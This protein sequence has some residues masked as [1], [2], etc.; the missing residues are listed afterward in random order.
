MVPLTAMVESLE[1]KGWSSALGKSL[2]QLQGAVGSIGSE[3]VRKALAMRN[4][5][6]PPGGIGKVVLGPQPIAEILHYVVLPSLTTGAFNAASSAYLGRF[7]NKVMDARLSL[8]DNPRLRNGAIHC[9]ISSEGFS[10]RPIEIVKQGRLAALLSN[11]D[12]AGR[13][14]ADEQRHEKLGVL[15]EISLKTTSGYR[16]GNEGRQRFDV[17]PNIGATNVVM[18]TRD[19]GTLEDMLSTVG[20]GVYLGNIWYTNP[21]NDLR[22]GDFASTISCESYLIRNG[23][24]AEPISQLAAH[25]WLDPPGV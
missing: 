2:V 13:L 19:G 16:L 18:R 4:G 15:R 20:D 22:A 7:G 24:L 17:E 1:A 5:A 10:A 21:I 25:R 8:I 23:K 6:R 12:H 14:T 11:H 3:V 9:R